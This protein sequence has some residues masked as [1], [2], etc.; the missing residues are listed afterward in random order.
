MQ[1]NRSHPLLKYCKFF[2]YADNPT[3]ARNLMGAVYQ[4]ADGVIAGGTMDT[5]C[6]GPVVVFDGSTTNIQWDNVLFDQFDS[7][8]VP[9][10]NPNNIPAGT[11][12]NG[13][14]VLV[15]FKIAVNADAG[16][17]TG[18]LSYINQDGGGWAIS[19]DDYSSTQFG[20]RFVLYSSTTAPYGYYNA[21]ARTPPASAPPPVTPGISIGCEDNLGSF[22]NEEHVFCGRYNYQTNM[23][24]ISFDGTPMVVTLQT[25]NGGGGTLDYFNLYQNTTAAT[26]CA[27]IFHSTGDQ[28]LNGTIA[29]VMIFDRYL[30]DGE[31]AV[32]SRGSPVGTFTGTSAGSLGTSPGSYGAGIPSDRWP[33]ID[34]FE[35]DIMVYVSP[36]QYSPPIYFG[37]NVP[38]HP[39]KTYTEPVHYGIPFVAPILPQ[40]YAPPVTGGP[41]AGAPWHPGPVQ[42][43]VQSM[44]PQP[45]AYVAQVYA[46]SITVGPPILGAPW[47]FYHGF[48]TPPTTGAAAGP[49]PPPPPPGP[50]P[51]PPATYRKALPLLNRNP[52]DDPRMKRFTNQLSEIINSLV[53]KGYLVQDLD[54][55]WHINPAP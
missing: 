30:S 24:E 55:E 47:T 38:G 25:G 51:P 54:G 37:P 42:L 17:G 44:P 39:W 48:V 19:Y 9:S 4:A 2:W 10:P 31:I 46:P 28:F 15:K 52:T 45:A 50:P 21:Y 35:D 33:F 22:Q 1:I 3:Y 12:M 29:W 5:G 32:L 7:L 27:G 14:T 40:I 18:I 16:G 6:A 26:L 41:I 20:L 34:D 43:P 8:P 23:P 11:P 36:Q 49:V 53:T 13:M